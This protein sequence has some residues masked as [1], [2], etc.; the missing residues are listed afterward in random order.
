MLDPGTLAFVFESGVLRF[1]DDGVLYVHLVHAADDPHPLLV[2]ELEAGVSV[3]GD[4]DAAALV[5]SDGSGSWRP[6]STLPETDELPDGLVLRF[7]GWDWAQVEMSGDLTVSLRGVGE[8]PGWVRAEHVHRLARPGARVRIWSGSSP[9]PAVEQERRELE[10][11][12]RD[13]EAEHAQ[14]AGPSG[15]WVGAHQAAP[16][17]TASMLLLGLAAATAAYLA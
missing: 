1:D 14:P 2:H 15:R 8:L 12:M 9:P 7:E 13:W 3:P 6:R 10:D 16:G 5:G 4:T 11:P 17:C